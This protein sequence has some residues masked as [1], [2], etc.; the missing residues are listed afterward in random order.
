MIG[1]TPVSLFPGN[2]YS[3][4]LFPGALRWELGERGR[5]MWRGPEPL[6]SFLSG[7]HPFLQ[8]LVE[9]CWE[10]GHGFHILSLKQSNGN[11]SCIL[12]SIWWETR[13]HLWILSIMPL[14][15]SSNLWVRTGWGHYRESENVALVPSLRNSE[16]YEVHLPHI[17]KNPFIEHIHVICKGSVWGIGV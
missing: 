13:R 10:P 11:F 8:T 17:L 4:S 1:C 2:M 14:C 12:G 6:S 7:S 15:F 16:D 9:D 5:S 3:L